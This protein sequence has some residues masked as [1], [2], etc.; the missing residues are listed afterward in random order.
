MGTRSSS[1]PASGLSPTVSAADV[2]HG[3]GRRAATRN[4][5]Q[6]DPAPRPSA[7]RPLP[8]RRSLSRALWRDVDELPS[9]AQLDRLI[10]RETARADRTGQ[11]FSLALFR[12][13]QP[14]D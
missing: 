10:A 6:G 14:T 5:R 7:G 1:G 9:G 12:V 13:T 8:P 4:E 11:P 3:V 2:A